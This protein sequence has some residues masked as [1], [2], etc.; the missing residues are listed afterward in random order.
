MAQD[1]WLDVKLDDTTDAA[2]PKRLIDDLVDIADSELTGKIC[3]ELTIAFQ[4][5][6]ECIGERCQQW[7]ED[8]CGKKV[9][10]N[11]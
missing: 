1:G 5:F 6:T 3:P 4:E 11:V 9:N 8:D 7:D 10:R 2:R